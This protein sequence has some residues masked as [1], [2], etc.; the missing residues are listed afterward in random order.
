[1]LVVISE[2]MQDEIYLEEER[3][4]YKGFEKIIFYSVKGHKYSN[5][6]LKMRNNMVCGEQD[7]AYSGILHRMWCLFTGGIT[8]SCVKEIIDMIRN[9]Q[10]NIDT[11]KQL[12]LFTAKK[13]LLQNSI[14]HSLERLG[15]EKKEQIV[16][17]SY[18]F[19]VGAA[20]AIE[21]K[22]IYRNSKSVARCHGQDL[23]EFRN[24]SNYLPY[25]KY[26]YSNIDE[27]Y[28]IS[29][30]GKQYISTKYPEYSYKTFVYRLGTKNI[31][32]ND[33]LSNQNLMI[34][35][36]SRI[37]PIKRLDRIAKTLSFIRDMKIT[38]IHY[39]DGDIQYKNTVERILQNAGNDINYEFKGFIDNK[40]LIKIYS[41]KPFTFFLNVSES[42]G[43]PV[44]IMEADSAGIPIV[45]T[46]VGGTREAVIDGYN[47]FLIEKN[48]SEHQLIEII[49]KFQNMDAHIYKEM[50]LNSR[51]IWEK[52][53]SCVLNYSAFAEQLKSVFRGC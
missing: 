49:K 51:K 24:R 16:F 44:S 40:E 20:A 42:E 2:F 36:C 39:G 8:F 38:W 3:K 17:Y 43:L 18:R 7:I 6:R 12:G 10:L 37:V 11:V 15:I 48:F 52:R 4:Y 34:V 1:M 41:E 47:G 28:C 26:L 30:D 25:R 35:T 19:G 21:L 14:S 32:V 33:L 31:A 45:A 53:F 50:C 27:L 29:E 5:T 46:D 23:F 13:K 9:K 22:K